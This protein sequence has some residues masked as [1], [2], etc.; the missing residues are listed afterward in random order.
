MHRIIMYAYT[1]YKF[2]IDWYFDVLF[3]PH[4]HLLY[5]Y[6][7][8]HKFVHKIVYIPSSVYILNLRPDLHKCMDD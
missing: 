1:T 6:Y 8:H 3:F 2:H 5:R 7:I 4:F